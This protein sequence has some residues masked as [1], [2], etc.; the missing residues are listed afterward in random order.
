MIQKWLL[1]LFLF[2]NLD[3]LEEKTQGGRFKKVG[4]FYRSCLTAQAKSSTADSK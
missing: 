3:L 4:D 1:D 2:C